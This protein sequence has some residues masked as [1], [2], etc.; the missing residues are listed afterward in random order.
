[1]RDH[2]VDSGHRDGA[3]DRHTGNHQ[4]QLAPSATARLSTRVH[5]EFLD[6]ATSADGR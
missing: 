5:Y 2:P 3:Q 4:S 1:M 6:A